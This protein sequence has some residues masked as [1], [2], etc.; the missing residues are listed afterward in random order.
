MNSLTSALLYAFMGP[1]M[2][3]I[4]FTFMA[5]E[6]REMMEN[7]EIFIISE[8]PSLLLEE[9]FLSHNF[10]ITKAAKIK[11][12]VAKDFEEKISKGL[13]PLITL[14]TNIS[15]NYKELKLVEMT[16]D[17]F[18]KT[19]GFQRMIARGVSPA[20]FMGIDVQIEDSNVVSY[21]SS[22]MIKM[23]L[24]FITTAGLYASMSIAIDMTAGERERLSLEPLLTQPVSANTVII[25]KLM[26]A[27]LF[28]FAGT[29]ITL[30]LDVVA[31]NM[32]PMDELGIK[33][34]MNFTS[35]LKVMLLITP[36]CH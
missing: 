25:G 21:G 28:A 30:G 20:S 29:F 14:K 3:F 6:K 26:I 17:Q 5:S 33:I 10:K 35:V 34:S 4:M 18:N 19:L 8:A 15:L 9:H 11:L 16:L 31:L 13:S 12:H 2:L 23:I 7:R 1:V 36:I 27:L 24:V 22:M 32:A